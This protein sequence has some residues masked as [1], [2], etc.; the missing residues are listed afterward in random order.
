MRV[1]ELH[2]ELH[3]GPLA[4]LPGNDADHLRL[5]QRQALVGQLLVAAG[6][7]LVDVLGQGEAAKGL[8][9]GRR[10]D[11]SLVLA[12]PQVELGEARE[13]FCSDKP[14]AEGRKRVPLGIAGGGLA[15]R[16]RGTRSTRSGT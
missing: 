9:V 2:E 15:F 7:E 16:P 5:G 8:G 6:D 11:A 4:E 14:K 3:A 13:A 12:G 1:G 10:E